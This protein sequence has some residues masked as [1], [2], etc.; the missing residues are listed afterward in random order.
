MAAK[1][2]VIIS[3]DGD[4]WRLE[5]KSTFKSTDIKFTDGVEFNGG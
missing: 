4:N 1:S 2:T 5:L 3:K